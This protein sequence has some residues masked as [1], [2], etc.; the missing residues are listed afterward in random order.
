MMSGSIFRISPFLVM[1]VILYG[2]D[3][4]LPLLSCH[5]VSFLAAAGGYGSWN[6]FS[7]R[8]VTA[9]ERM[10]FELVTTH[11]TDEFDGGMHVR[12][13]CSFS[14]SLPDTETTPRPMTCSRLIS[15]SQP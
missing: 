1:A 11:T 6:G 12:E 10:S 2:Y 9:Q 15:L 4:L 14:T 5:T 13:Y 3:V 8:N 7:W